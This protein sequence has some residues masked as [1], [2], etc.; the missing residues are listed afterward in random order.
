MWTPHV[1]EQK[2]LI[3]SKVESYLLIFKELNVKHEI[4]P[5][6]FRSSDQDENIT[7]ILVK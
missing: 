2:P 1:E 5:G 3:F 7:K 6:L 4:L